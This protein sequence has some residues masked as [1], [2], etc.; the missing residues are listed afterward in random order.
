MPP[1]DGRRGPQTPNPDPNKPA[2]WWT[3]G[4][5]EASEG[6]LLKGHTRP[7]SC[8]LEPWPTNPRHTHTHTHVS[9]QKHQHAY[10][11]TFA[12]GWTVSQLNV[13]LADAPSQRLAP[14]DFHLFALSDYRTRPNQLWFS[15][16]SHTGGMLNDTWLDDSLVRAGWIMCLWVFDNHSVH[17]YHRLKSRFRGQSDFRWYEIIRVRTERAFLFW[18][19]VLMILRVFYDLHERTAL[20][21]LTSWNPNW[22]D[23][24]VLGGIRKRRVVLLI[25]NK[26]MI[27]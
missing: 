16:M 17:V 4:N 15:Q 9:M 6:V 14:F 8:Y 24:K 25:W 19:H 23:M 13:R 22:A 21:E 18:C 27:V 10:K 12:G 1:L 3:P 20:L 11:Q 26:I 2:C 7:F 5:P